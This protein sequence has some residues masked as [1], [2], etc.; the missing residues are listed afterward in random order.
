MARPRDFDEKIALEKAMEL[1]WLKGYN[2]TSPQDLLDTLGLSRSSLYRTFKDKHTLFM[3]AL[4]YYQEFSTAEIKKVI[5]PADSVKEA[6][7]KVLEFITDSVVSDQLH[8][9]CFMLN[10]EIE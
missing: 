6:I 8:K 7:R 4:A 2:G 9:G 10:S 1:F 5:D 3:K